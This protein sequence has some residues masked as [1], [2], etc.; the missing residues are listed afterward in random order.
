MSDLTP[1][2]SV[3]LWATD[4]A[5]LIRFLGEAGGLAVEQSFPGYAELRA[6]NARIVLHAD[7]DAYRGHPWYDAIRKE[8]VARGI[9]AE[10]RLRVPD[11]SAAYARALRLGALAIQAPAQVD[12]AEECSVMGPD[13]FL[14]S[15]WSTL[16][17][18]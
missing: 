18:D 3:V 13:G 14:F 16:E 7:D 10:L 15:F 5:G 4:L 6:A 1:E 9:G 8:G 11:A 17:D 2:L 12:G